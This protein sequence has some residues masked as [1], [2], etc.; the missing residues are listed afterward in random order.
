MKTAELQ[1]RLDGCS[2][3]SVPDRM[4]TSELW[5][6]F[7]FSFLTFSSIRVKKKTPNPLQWSFCL[8]WVLNL[9]PLSN[10]VRGP[11][12]FPEFEFDCG[13]SKCV[14]HRFTE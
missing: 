6:Y 13:F 9:Y 8:D 11:D 12:L 7:P 14:I 2:P 5:C 4:H 10:R 1:T 3:Q